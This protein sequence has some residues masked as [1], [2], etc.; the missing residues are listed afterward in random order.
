MADPRKQGDPAEIIAAQLREWRAVNGHYVAGDIIRAL[1]KA[2]FV[3]VAA[4]AGERR[5]EE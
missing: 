3:I 5:G 4:E 2:G 1:A